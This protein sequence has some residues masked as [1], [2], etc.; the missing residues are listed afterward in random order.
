MSI[1]FNRLSMSSLDFQLIDEF[2]LTA[3][4]QSKVK[5]LLQTCFG[6]PQSAV[7]RIYYKQI[8]SRRLLV[9]H[10]DDL[11]GHMGSEHRVVSAARIPLKIFGVID[12]CVQPECRSAGIASSMLQWLE[13]LGKQYGI[14]FIIL[15]ALNPCLYERNGYFAPANPLRWTKIH[16]HE[17]IGIGEEVLPELM[18]KQLGDRSWPEG[19]IDLLG[20]QF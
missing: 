9:W 3:H 5:T 1:P 11:I 10:N 4:Q 7:T 12:L 16:D 17:I 13:N 8:P 6:T 20:Y 2:R 18:V 15:F 14:E 19:L